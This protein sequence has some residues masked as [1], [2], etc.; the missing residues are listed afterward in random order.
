M[1]DATIDIAFI[2]DAVTGATKAFYLLRNAVE[3]AVEFVQTF[4]GVANVAAYKKARYMQRYHRR[5][6]KIARR[7]AGKKY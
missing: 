7:L 4:V 2:V 1:S 3:E 6:T 5:G